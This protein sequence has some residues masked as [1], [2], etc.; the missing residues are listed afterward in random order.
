[1]PPLD[2]HAIFWVI[3]MCSA[4]PDSNSLFKASNVATYTTPVAGMESD[5]VRIIASTGNSL[6]KGKVV[7]TVPG[8][9]HTVLPG[10]A[11]HV[12]EIVKKYDV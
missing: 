1:M 5:A 3:T 12:S 4:D 11:V 9:A 8:S 6:G 7:V 2:D 10:G